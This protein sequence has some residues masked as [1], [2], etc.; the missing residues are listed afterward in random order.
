MINIV[1]R[2]DFDIL[3]GE[4]SELNNEFNFHSTPDTI[5]KKYFHSDK[6]KLKRLKRSV[7]LFFLFE[8][9]MLIAPREDGIYEK[10]TIDKRYDAFIAAILKP[11]PEKIEIISN[12]KVLTWN[13]DLQFELA[14][15]KYKELKI[16]AIQNEIQSNPKISNTAGSEFTNNSFSIV[17]L[18]GIA[19]STAENRPDYMGEVISDDF[20]RI[21]YIVDVYHGM[22]SANSV[23]KNGGIELLSFAWEKFNPDYTIM[24]NDLL[25]KAFEIANDTDCLVINGYSFPTFNRLIDKRILKE[26]KKLNKVYI[27]S[28]QYNDLEKIIKEIKP[29]IN[30]ENIGYWNQFFIPDWS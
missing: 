4:I 23:P 27:Q 8:Q 5:A 7:I 1:N 14:Y 29:N 3:I 17:H 22:L 26:M 10:E 28:P 13:Y 11:I 16:T 2:N 30:I 24:E 19:Y 6:E 21:N 25:N 20:Q 18:N 15:S 12:I 9:T